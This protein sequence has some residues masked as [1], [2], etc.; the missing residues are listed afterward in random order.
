[1]LLFEMFSC[2][3]SD[4]KRILILFFFWAQASPI[5]FPAD[6]KNEKNNHSEKSI[7][8]S[9]EIE[10]NMI[11]LTIFPF[12]YESNGIPFGSYTEGNCRPKLCF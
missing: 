11:T 7:L 10:S 12:E 3:I 8:I 9:F 4:S 5:F 6:Q 2:I 1:M